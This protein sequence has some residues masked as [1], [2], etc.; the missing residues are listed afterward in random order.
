[1]ALS[2]LSF[3]KMG[4][5]ELQLFFRFANASG[6]FP[7]RLI[8][9]QSTG[10]FKR[11]EGHWHHFANWWFVVVLTGHVFYVTVFLYMNCTMIIEDSNLSLPVFYLV[12]FSL[13]LLCQL[14]FTITPRL[15]LICFRHLE[16]ALLN[17]Q[18]IDKELG[19]MS[20]HVTRSNSSQRRTLIGIFLTILMV[21]SLNFFKV[22]YSLN[23]YD[24]FI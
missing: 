20:S 8:F 17:L 23:V 21:S 12:T 11:F 24:Y 4:V 15:F 5:E 7:F 3:L 10:K 9:D 19:R 2:R 1:M 14:L 13:F 6:L 18:L 16:T 22:N